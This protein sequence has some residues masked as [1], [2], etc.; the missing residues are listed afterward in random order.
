MIMPCMNSTS[1]REV[2]GKVPCVDGGRVLLG[3]PGAPG[4]T[5]TGF[6]AS[7]CTARTTGQK[8][9]PPILTTRNTRVR[10]PRAEPVSGLSSQRDS[11]V[12][13]LGIREKIAIWTR[14]KYCH[15]TGNFH[16]G[17]EIAI[18]ASSTCSQQEPRTC[19]AANCRGAVESAG[20]SSC[21]FVAL[22]D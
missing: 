17:K 14:G 22:G 15:E 3:V 20:V 8:N 1:A 19:K 11:T 18:M 21:S 16:S 12:L 13:R 6:A 2:G 7:V 4:C 9:N 10:M 5:T